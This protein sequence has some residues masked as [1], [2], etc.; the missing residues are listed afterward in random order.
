MKKRF[1]VYVFCMLLLGKTY[2]FAQGG[3]IDTTFGIKGVKKFTF[4]ISY[5]GGT[6]NP[7]KL[8]EDSLNRIT[9]VGQTTKSGVNHFFVTRW[10]ANGSLDTTFGNSGTFFIPITSANANS[11]A[12]QQLQDDGKLLL[13][14][15]VN[16]AQLKDIVISRYLSN[17]ALDAGFGNN[18]QTIIP[19]SYLD[20]IPSDLT[21]A[22]DG[23]IIIAATTALGAS[24]TDFATIRLLPNGLID[25]SFN[26]AGIAKLNISGNDNAKKVL[27]QADG[28]IIVGGETTLTNKDLV[29]VRYLPNGNLDTTY[30]TQ[31][32]IT[33]PVGSG[34]DLLMDLKLMDDGK[35]MA[36]AQAVISGTGGAVVQLNVN[37]SMN[38]SFGFSGVKPL[39]YLAKQILLDS[40]GVFY[41]H[42]TNF[43]RRHLPNG[44][45]DSGFGVSG[46][47]NFN[48]HTGG[49]SVFL[50]QL[51]DK[52]LRCAGQKTQG[53]NSD[54]V[55]SGITQNGLVLNTFGLSGVRTENYDYKTEL[56]KFTA[57]AQTSLSDRSLV[58]GGTMILNSLKYFIVTKFKPNGD[59]DSSFASF[60][61]YIIS[62]NATYISLYVKVRPDNNI[63]VATRISMYPSSTVHTSLFILDPSGKIVKNFGDSGFVN[64]TLGG[65]PLINFQSDGK[66]IIGVSKRY[67]PD[68][69]ADTSFHAPVF[70]SSI[71]AVKVLINDYILL[72]FDTMLIRLFPNGQVDSTFGTKGYFAYSTGYDCNYPNYKKRYFK[73]LVITQE[74]LTNNIMLGGYYR[75]GCLPPTSYIMKVLY[76]NE[77]GTLNGTFPFASYGYFDAE[78]NIIQLPDRGFLLSA[79]SSQNNTGPMYLS[80]I[81]RIYPLGYDDPNFG[82]QGSILGG[83][84]T[85]FGISLYNNSQANWLRCIENYDTIYLQRIKFNATPFVDFSANKTKP[86]FGDT[87]LLTSSSYMTAKAYEWSLSPSKYTYLQGTDLSSANPV[88]KFNKAGLYSISLKVFYDDTFVTLTKTNYIELSPVV[89]FHANKLVISQ[90]ETNSFYSYFNGFPTSYFW[91]FNPSSISYKNGTDSLSKNPFVQFHSPGKYDVSFTAVYNDTTVLSERIQYIEVLPQTGMTENIKDEIFIYPNPTHSTIVIESNG[92]LQDAICE[93]YDIQGR[94]FQNYTSTVNDKWSITLPENPGVYFLKI[95]TVDGKQWIRK[96][97]KE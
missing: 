42:Y 56:G 93:V 4:G 55:V 30:G 47:Y 48:T 53:T 81:K 5:K 19:V 8:F 28:K 60:G 72:S 44:N 97:V 16:T 76:L 13:A 82:Y 14:G 23:K 7:Y 38:T 75:Y 49:N 54:L 88:L 73:I 92:L 17:G 41:T 2:V 6:T 45:L 94:L 18:G 51:N 80:I 46:V 37:G 31:G 83:R 34:D 86:G 64:D 35:L 26:T 61:S 66:I 40:A 63:Q 1:S 90:D 59:R 25:S 43:V 96:V 74:K 58:V 9:I 10:F 79:N 84:Y 52:S 70:S 27:V 65:G 3:G 12:I 62:V 91:S 67:F 87:V 32:K 21:I 29:F 68:G 39:G 24:G 85:Y 15:T 50:A 33:Y 36:L 11:F 71:Y 22:P 57:F 89:Y 77:N 20:D 78:S 95:N 69:S